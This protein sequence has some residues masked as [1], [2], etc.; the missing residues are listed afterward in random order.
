[1]AGFKPARYKRL[2]LNLNNSSIHTERILNYRVTNGYK[3]INLLPMNYSLLK[4][5]QNVGHIFH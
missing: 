2:F 5:P 4:I 1:M 3:Y